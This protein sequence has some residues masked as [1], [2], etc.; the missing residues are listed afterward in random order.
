VEE[1]KTL[2]EIADLS[3]LW[4]EG[5]LYPNDMQALNDQTDVDMIIP[6]VSGE[7][8]TGKINFVN[9]ELNAGDKINL[10]RIELDNSKNL[11]QP[12]MMAYIMINKNKKKVLAV[13]TNAV[14][15]GEKGSLVWML[16]SDGKF[17]FSKVT[18]GIQNRDLTE[19][20]SGISEGKNIVTSGAYLLNSEFVFKKGTD[21]I[22]YLNKKTNEK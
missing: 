17:D 18:T 15:Q 7:R 14:I 11:F 10:I 1:G 4:V 5:Q 16:T 19:I 2:L 22:T 21:P 3:S 13:P 9:P 6:S 20:V 12:G 8:I